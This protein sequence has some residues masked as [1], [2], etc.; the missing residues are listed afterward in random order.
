MNYLV[1]LLSM[2]LM[3]KNETNNC[4]D[5]SYSNVYYSINFYIKERL[6]E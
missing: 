3:S 5:S 6:Y 2:I 1:S 4:I